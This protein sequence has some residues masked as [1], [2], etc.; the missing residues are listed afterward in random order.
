MKSSNIQHPNFNLLDTPVKF[1]G[2]WCLKFL[3]MLVLGAWSF[4]H[5]CL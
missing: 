1:V 3:W 5:E 2:A 4:S